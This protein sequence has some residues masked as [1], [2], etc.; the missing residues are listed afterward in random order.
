[1]DDIFD[2]VAPMLGVPGG[3]GRSR[4]RRLLGEL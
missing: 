4:Q 3:E 1:M 2:E